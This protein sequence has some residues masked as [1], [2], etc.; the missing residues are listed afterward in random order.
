MALHSLIH[1]NHLLTARDLGSMSYTS[2][3]DHFI[4]RLSKS[5][6]LSLVLFITA[7][8]EA[9]FSPVLPE[10][11]LLVVLAYRKDLSWKF[12]SALSALGSATGALL[13]YALGYFLF[14]AYGAQILAFLHG[15][16]V[17]ATA[18]TLFEQNAFMA[19][20]V[21]S[22]TPLPDR[23]FSFLAGTFHV[24][25]PIIFV[26]TFLG[27]FVRAGV[28]AY[29]SYEYGDEARV[30]IKKH[31]HFAVIVLVIIVILYTLYKI[32]G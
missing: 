1:Q 10:A 23:V 7:F 9:S 17:S 16:V 30:Y 22:L 24:S 31:T 20:F 29:L 3:T 6:H 27:R 11:L 28:V 4:E 32:Y 14:D 26:A 19:Q 12:L 18:K 15:E 8:L 2:K 13:M 21:A 25:V 5:K